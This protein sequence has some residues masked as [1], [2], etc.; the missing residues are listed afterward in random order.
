MKSAIDLIPQNRC[1][2]CYGCF[3]ACT[4]NAIDMSLNEEGFLTPHVDRERCIE[5][6]TCQKHCAMI[7][8]Q[9]PVDCETPVL[10][11]ASSMDEGIR[12]ESSSG[13]IF[14]E[15][16]K[17]ILKNGGVVFGAA[18]SN[19]LTVRHVFVE[20]EEDLRILRGSKYLQSH[21]GKAYREAISIGIQGRPVLFSGTPCQIAAL[22]TFFDPTDLE[23]EIYTCEVICHGVP[24]ESVF[25]SYLDYISRSKHLEIKEY[26]FRD[27]TID[28]KH[29]GTKVVFT[30]GEERFQVH[31]KDSFMIGYLRNIYL[32]PV[33]YECPFARIPRISDITLGDFWGVPKE[34]DDSRG[35]SVVVVNTPKGKR[36]L[37]RVSNIKKVRVSLEQVAPYNPR[38]VSGHLKRRSNR[39]GFYRLLKMEG[40]L[41]VMKKYLKPN[42]KFKEYLS[43]V[44]FRF[45]RLAKRHMP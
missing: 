19:S 13:G 20:S 14:T 45:R 3:N 5:C 28:W 31:K 16:A 39:E 44:E 26:G 34:L 1:S 23:I 21:L 15:L 29:Y 8:T 43:A 41:A 42:P 6:G 38:L 18:F 32:R 36:L 40:F 25:R 7:N 17:V 11:A 33:C 30:N 37:D 27:K 24:S 9:I 4:E 22:N 10:F 2:G 35:V 12:I